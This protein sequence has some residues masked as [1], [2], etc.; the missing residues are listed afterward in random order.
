M[1]KGLS[2]LRDEYVKCRSWGHE[3]DT[4][5]PLRRRAAWGTLLSLRCVRCG[6]E[7][8]DTIDANGDI[9]TREYKY[10]DGYRLTGVARGDR[11]TGA[12]I[13]LEV[14]RRLRSPKKAR[15]GGLRSA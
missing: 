15:R 8:H 3:W 5:H 4:F 12:E 11:A 6:T 1:A 7:R 13:R 14:L 10:A 2:R 9:S